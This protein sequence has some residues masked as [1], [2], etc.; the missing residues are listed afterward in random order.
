MFRNTPGSMH[1]AG[2]ME[3]KIGI[4]SSNVE[5]ANIEYKV[6]KVSTS[7]FVLQNHKYYINETMRSKL[8]LLS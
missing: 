3:N 7:G 4:E 5:S 8:C 6:L 2:G 1:E